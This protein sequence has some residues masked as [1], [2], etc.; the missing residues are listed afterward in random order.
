M[1]SWVISALFMV[2]MA[3]GGWA[4]NNTLEDI[5]AD[6]SEIKGATLATQS[7]LNTHLITHPDK[8]L[9]NSIDKLNMRV[10]ILEK[11]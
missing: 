4:I 2:V 10:E 9:E 1:V 11:Q 8:A 5:K 3:I 7:T 6:I